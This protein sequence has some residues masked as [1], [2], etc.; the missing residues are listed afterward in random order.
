MGVRGQLH[1]PTSLSLVK[2]NP[3]IPIKGRV[4]GPRAGL[5]IFDRR[6][7][8][9]GTEVGFLG[10]PALSLLLKYFALEACLIAAV[11]RSV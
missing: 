4:V 6:L 10:C 5:E 8:L 7:L 1:T 11:V 2:K 9:S 3:Q